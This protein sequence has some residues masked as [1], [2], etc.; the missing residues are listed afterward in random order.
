MR[1]PGG[2]KGGVGPVCAHKDSEGLE[3]PPGLS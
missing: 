1:R 3:W 2:V